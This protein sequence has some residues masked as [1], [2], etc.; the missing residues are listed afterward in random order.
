MRSFQ[1]A[2]PQA[3]AE[4]LE[5]LNEHGPSASILAG[6]TDLIVRLRAGRELPAVVIDLKR[7]RDLQ[8]GIRECETFLRIGACVTMAELIANAR[9]RSCFPALADAAHNVGSMQIRNRATL[10]GNVCNASPAAD[11][12]PALLVYDAVVN[13]VSKDGPRCVALKDFFTA[14]GRTVARRG[15][16]V[17]SL[18]LPLPTAPQA[19]CFERLTRR[20]GVDLATVNLCCLVRASGQTVFAYGAVAPTPLLFRDDSGKLADPNGDRSEKEAILSSFVAGAS[21]RTDVRAAKDYRSAML[22]AMS[23]RALQTALSR[24]DG[25]TGP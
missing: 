17:E 23:R 5:L 8:V 20:R 3:L 22:L 1:Y 9:V 11:T 18:D 4:V 13:L 15:E 10:G 14:P 19:A 21:P 16:L 2:R 7:V 12:A 24:L 6:G 25:E